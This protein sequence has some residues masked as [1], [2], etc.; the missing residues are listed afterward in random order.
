MA[1]MKLPAGVVCDTDRHGNA[2]Y[3][4]WPDRSQKRI[5]LNPKG[6]EVG[7]RDFFKRLDDCMAGRVLPP[8]KNAKYTPAQLGWLIDEYL[9]SPEF[10]HLAAATQDQRRKVLI[11]L[12]DEHGD[13]PKLIPR[14]AIRAGRNARAATPAAAHNRIKIMSALYS[15]GMEQGLCDENPARGFKRIGKAGSF[16]TW[17]RE[18]C[19]Q[20][21]AHWAIGTTP[22]LAYDLLYWT[23]QRVSDVWALGPQHVK[24]GS[25]ELTQQKTGAKLVLPIM[26][27]LQRS[28]DAFD[29]V[30]L[31]FLPYKTVKSLQT[32]FAKW[33]KAAGLPKG[34]SPH[35]LRKAR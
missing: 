28:L 10:A 9:T 32:A 33:A 17:T 7:S 19:A 21:E 11:A 29:F 30:D 35:G 14:E 15:W 31:R 8:R 25:I 5:R 3:Y 2:R 6:V 24:H 23:G 26:P 13:K 22:R 20:F 18:E 12:Q 4:W 34:C 16:H 27:D 1:D